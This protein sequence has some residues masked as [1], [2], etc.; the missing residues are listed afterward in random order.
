[1]MKRVLV[2]SFLVVLTVV[3]WGQTDARVVKAGAILDGFH[4]GAEEVERFLHLVY[5]T[6]ADRDPAEGWEVRV[7]GV[8]EDIQEFYADEMGRHGFGR[9]TIR[10]QRGAADKMVIHLVRGKGNKADYVKGDGERIASEC[11]PVLRAAGIDPERETVFFFC[12]LADWED[13]KFTHHS[14]YYGTGSWRRGRCW[15]SDDIRQ[16]IRNIVVKQKQVIDGEYG[17]MS[18]GRHVGIFIGGIAHELGHAI[19]L[20]HNRARGDESE[21]G[22]ALMGAGNHTYRQE[23]R[24]PEKKGAFLTL[25]HAMRLASH[26]MFSGST[27]AMQFDGGATVKD[28]V[29]TVVGKSFLLSGKVQGKLPVYAVVGYMDPEGGGDYDAPTVVAVP[30]A[31]GHFSVSCDQLR[32]GRAGELRLA[33]LHVNGANT[34]LRYPYVV[35][36]D[37]VPDVSG[38][39]DRTVMLPFVDAIRSGGVGGAERALVEMADRRGADDRLVL[40]AEE[41]LAARESGGSFDLGGAGVEVKRVRLGDVKPESGS[42]G[43]GRPSYNRVPMGQE[44]I[45]SGG[46]VFADGIYGHA[47]SRFVY[48]LDQ[49]WRRLSG[50]AGLQDGKRGSVIFVVRVDGKEVWRSQ[51]VTGGKRLK[52]D[53][54]VVEAE[55]LELVVENAG[56]GNGADWGMW[57]GVG[58]ER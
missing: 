17:R 36:G 3:S 21:R 42:V 43:W 37:G 50:E 47:P 44:L 18:L 24:H 38:I 6:P 2:F 35:G 54:D 39:E 14:P 41:V 55:E 8:M 25:A 20:P 52:F 10:L 46:K 15:A 19:G 48:R 7:P 23:R 29:V 27:K 9:R 31:E 30:D 57:L 1:M 58:L 4:E 56:D 28:E 34:V 40:L 22:T 51:R 11:E 45:Q 13:E 53:V 26:P 12:N 49:G 16:D 33:V 5:W 32:A